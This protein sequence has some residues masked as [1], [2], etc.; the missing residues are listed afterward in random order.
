M[1]RANYAGAVYLDNLNK[2]L[3][4]MSFVDGKKESG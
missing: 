3:G 2:R 4:D 1:S